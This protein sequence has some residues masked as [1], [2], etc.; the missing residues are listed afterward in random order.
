MGTPALC[1]LGVFCL[2]GPTSGHYTLFWYRQ[3]SGQEPKL[4]IYFSNK[5]L[6]DDSGMPKKWF[7]AEMP[8][9]S[10]SILEIQP[11]EP[12]DSAT[13]LCASSVD[14]ALQSNPFPPPAVLSKGLSCCFTKR[15]ERLWGSDRTE[16]AKVST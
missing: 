6:M 16:N 1:L 8:D 3:T 11:T 15:N 4:L 13:Y 9:D 12:R 10:F 7:S 5:A 2:L 14:T